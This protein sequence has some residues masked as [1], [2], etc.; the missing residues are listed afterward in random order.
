MKSLCSRPPIPPTA[1]A[2]RAG[3]SENSSS[4]VSRSDHAPEGFFLVFLRELFS[5]G[6]SE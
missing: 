5:E 3:P 2:A 1:E 4:I 6:D